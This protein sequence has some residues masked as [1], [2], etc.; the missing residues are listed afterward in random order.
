MQTTERQFLP[1]SGDPGPIPLARFLPHL[2]PGVF[3]RWLAENVAAGEWLL[4]PIGGHPG[5]ALEAARSGQRVLVASNN[6]IL[7]F[8][9]EV[10][11]SGPKKEDFEAALAALGASRRGEERLERYLKSIYLTPCA[12]CGRDVPAE[13]F[14]WQKDQPQPFARIYHCPACGDEGERPVVQ[15]DLDRLNALGS[16]ALHRSRALARVVQAGSPT[17]QVETAIKTYLPR[18]LIVLTTLINKSEGLSLSPE[19]KALLTALL[20]SACDEANTLWPHGSSRPRPRQLTIPSQFRENN[21]WKA[22][23]DAISLW[24]ASSTKVRLTHWPELPPPGG[25]ICLY[26]GRVKSLLPLPENI[27]IKAL[28]T[29]LPRPNQAFWTLCALWSGWLWGREAV[30]PLRGSLE[31]R[32]Y[33]WHWMTHAISGALSGVNARLPAGTPLFAL[34]SELIPGFLLSLFCGPLTAG[35]RLESLA[36]DESHDQAQFYWR[37][38]P[39]AAPAGTSN[40]KT[41]LAQAFREHLYRRG[42]PAPYLALFAAGLQ[43]MAG[44]NLLPQ[45]ESGVNPDLLGRLQG[46]M[47][48]VLLDSKVFERFSPHGQSEEGSLWGLKDYGEAVQPLS[49]RVER[50]IVKLLL[51]HDPLTLEEVHRQIDQDFPGLLNSSRGTGRRLPRFIRRDSPGPA[52]HLAPAR[53]RHRHRPQT[54]PAHGAPFTRPPGR[55]TRFYLPGRRGFTLANRRPAAGLPVF[56]GGLGHRQPACLSTPAAAALPLRAGHPWRSRLAVEL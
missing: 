37:S 14:L 17:E 34:A 42:E 23:E 3:S 31:R 51:D 50:A 38:A 9:L 26:T 43:G 8:M 1:G 46:T 56:P 29:I 11:A 32:R 16:D 52:R 20:I 27:P 28:A 40:P 53:A 21:L 55:H 22:L 47:S 44:A 24:L 48:E 45:H 35:Y 15:A 33:D 30:Q 13:A 39:T 25:G 6:P 2:P 12:V 18:P 4:D 36:Y 54:R 49:D 7:T 19:R 5:L 10:L 41:V